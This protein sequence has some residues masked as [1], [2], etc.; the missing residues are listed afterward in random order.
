MPMFVICATEQPRVGQR[1]PRHHYFAVDAA[2]AAAAIATFRA[3]LRGQC[4]AQLPGDTV[5]AD[6]AQPGEVLRL[7]V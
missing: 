5:T 4:Y 3:S 2:D 1:K 7:S 6:A